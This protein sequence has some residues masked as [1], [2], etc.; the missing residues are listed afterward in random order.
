MLA[1]LRA[2]PSHL[3]YLVLTEAAASELGKSGATR[4]RVAFCP[5]PISTH[6]LDRSLNGDEG[7]SG[8]FSMIKSAADVDVVRR[9]LLALP[10][11]VSGCGFNGDGVISV[12]GASA[13][14]LV[15]TRRFLS[16]QQLETEL[17][18]ARFFLFPAAENAYAYTASGLACAAASAGAHV[19]GLSN[20][21]MNSYAKLYP[22]T[23]HV[24]EVGM[25]AARSKPTESAPLGQPATDNLAE[26]ARCI[27]D[28]KPAQSQSPR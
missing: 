22:Q 9:L 11:A 14:E 19:V 17:A 12:Q 8:A 15:A 10:E 7:R 18:S 25:N 13:E 4:A 23:F 3:T 1:A 5:H 6:V 2:A 28:H 24:L 27:L 20:G 21:F 26:V 16:R